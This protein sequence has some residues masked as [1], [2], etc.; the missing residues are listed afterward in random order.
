M[1]LKTKN[2]KLLY[3]KWGIALD[4]VKFKIRKIC[5]LKKKTKNDAIFHM[6]FS[7]L[8][9]NNIQNYI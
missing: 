2:Y 8:E 9:K 7:F 4:M 6:N 1:K 3:L 5:L